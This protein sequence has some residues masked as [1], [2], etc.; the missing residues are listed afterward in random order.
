MYS[1]ARHLLCSFSIVRRSCARLSLQHSRTRFALCWI[2]PMPLRLWRS[3]D[4]SASGS[5]ASSHSCRRVRR[6]HSDAWSR[7]MSVLQNSPTGTPLGDDG[8][9]GA[10]GCIRAAAPSAEV[11]GGSSA[12]SCSSEPCLGFFRAVLW[13]PSHGE[14]GRFCPC[15]WVWPSFCPSSGSR[16]SAFL[17]SAGG[18]ARGLARGWPCSCRPLARPPSLWAPIVTVL[19]RR[20]SARS[21]APR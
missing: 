20:L 8:A 14:G 12:R 15:W 3:I 10:G 11:L 1:S 6:L 17:F 5:T 9:V 13:H 2:M 7:P 4:R 16:V 21:S 19:D 18:F